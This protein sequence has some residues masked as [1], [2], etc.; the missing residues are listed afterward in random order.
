[1][2][3]FSK[4]KIF[5]IISVVV[6]GVFYASANLLPEKDT[7]GIWSRV[8]PNNK[9]NLGL[10][11]QG[12][13]HIL[14]DTDIDQVKKER[15]ESIVSEIRLKLGEEHIAY[16]RLFLSK[17]LTIELSV[18]NVNEM[19]R[20]EKVLKGL[21]QTITDV[22]LSTKNLQGLSVERKSKNTFNVELNPQAVSEWTS[23]VVRQSIEIIRRRI[24]ELG[25]TEPSI[26]RQGKK[27]IIVQLPGVENPERL[28]KLLGQT[29]KL[30]FHLVDQRQSVNSI[31]KM[32]RPP[33][34]TKILYSAKDTSQPYLIKKRVMLSGERLVDSNV[35]FDPSTGTPEV[36]FRFDTAGAKIFSSVTRKNI[37]K[38]FAIVLDDQVISAPVIQSAILGGVGRIT[39]GFSVE[40]ANDLA[41]LLRAGAL[42][43]PLNVL[44]ER[45]VGAGLGSDSIQSGKKASIIA[46]IVVM[47]F[48]AMSYKLFGV[49]AN[50]ALMIN[51]VLIVAVLSM[52]QATLTLPGIA[53]I[54][55]TIGMA[56]DA[57]VLI[58]ERIK[59][60]AYKGKTALL[61]IEAGYKKALGTILDANITTFIIAMILFFMGSG[62]V[63]GFAVTLGIGIVTSIFTAFTL[64]RF[65]IVLWVKKNNHHRITLPL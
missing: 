21:N 29:A 14:L 51:I 57:N 62:S 59:E 25:I 31:V 64:T 28:R 33:L 12:G 27:R 45:S 9:L 41:I 32:K 15:L 43:A 34:G 5:F 46:F 8:L 1:M 6:L 18:T 4:L 36:N 7:G 17:E 35:G 48:I 38:P 19:E 55:L 47:I 58:F 49:F 65:M 52:L 11:L 40:E 2:L 44:E 13:A 16:N 20:V 30:N 10:D 50:L 3:Y 63:R 53:G 42:P 39:G 61:A 22:L 26:Q 23:R 24:D 37:G 54:V 60:E 56:V